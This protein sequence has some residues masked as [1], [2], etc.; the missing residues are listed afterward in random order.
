M[1]RDVSLDK[2]RKNEQLFEYLHEK[3]INPRET[4]VPEDVMERFSLSGQEQTLIQNLLHE[5][6]V[7]SDTNWNENQRIGVFLH[8]RFLPPSYHSHTYHEI[9]Y[10]LE[11]TV[12][13]SLNGRSV[14]LEPGDFCFI[15]PG[16][17][18][19][20]SVFNADTLL[21]N[22][23]IRSKALRDVFRHVF[24][25]ENPLSTFYNAS[26]SEDIGIPA[27][28]CRTNQ[29]Q[30][31][32]D[33]VKVIYDYKADKVREGYGEQIGD[34]MVEQ[35]LLLLLQ[36]H[37]EDFSDGWKTVAYS[38]ETFAV[39]NYISQNAKDLTLSS[40]AQRF[41]YSESY[42]SRFIKQH[43]GL[44]FSELLKNARLDMAANLLRN[45][46]LSVSNIIAE[47]GYTGKAHFY[48]IFQ[49][50]FGLTPAELRAKLR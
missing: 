34:M 21:I 39:L 32:G 19:S 28:F 46:D 8:P 9:K 43:T 50:K 18:H 45:T 44:S 6:T 38:R 24:T 17:P 41:N 13:L 7:L 2:L 16:V 4:L 22:I 10:V 42:M 25:A 5:G 47:V 23:G 37:T 33:L 15:A 31:L 3:N 29:D 20:C 35:Q 27:M 49:A 14:V 12:A 11:G 30:E 48:R 36:R 40:L 1:S 26:G